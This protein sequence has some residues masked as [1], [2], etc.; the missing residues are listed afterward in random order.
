FEKEKKEVWTEHLGELVMAYNCT[1][2]A[3]TGYSPY[4]LMF[5]RRPRL[6]VDF[7]FPTLRGEGKAQM[8]D[9]FIAEIRSVMRSA[10]EAAREQSTAEAERQKR[11]YDKNAGTSTLNPGDLVLVRVD[12]YQGKR[13]VKD[14]WGDHPWEVVRQIATGVPAYEVKSPEGR[15]NRIIHR[16]RLLFLAAQDD[17]IPV[18]AIVRELLTKHT[19]DDPDNIPKNGRDGLVSQGSRERISQ[20]ES[21]DEIGI[22]NMCRESVG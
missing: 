8:L 20:S 12:G 18:A 4:Y 11:H 14:R 22:S 7:M 21:A 17:S 2:S 5:G 10:Y 16:N 1:R 15:S 6:P 13:K 3:V 19:E 9:E